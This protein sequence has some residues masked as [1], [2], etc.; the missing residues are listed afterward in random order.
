MENI[1]NEQPSSETETTEASKVVMTSASMTASNDDVD[2]EK[3]STD[4]TVENIVGEISY[5]E[6][7]D[8]TLDETMLE[9]IPHN[10]TSMQPVKTSKC[11]I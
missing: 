11:C 7:N 10:A 1:T 8:E 9:D 3:T 6:Q 2:V 4:V 5:S